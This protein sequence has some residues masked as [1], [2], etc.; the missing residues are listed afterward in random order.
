M[1]AELRTS[2]DIDATPERVWQVLTDLPAYPQ[3]NPFVTA[4]E[5][6]VAEG[7]RLSLT[8]LPVN[9]LIRPTL[10]ATVVEAVPGQRLR[11]QSRMDRLGLPGLLDVEHTISLTPNGGGVRLWQDSHMSGLLLPLT[12]GALNRRRLAAFHAMNA[13]LKDRSEAAPQMT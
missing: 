11:L 2:V 4:A 9:A 1:T 10:R 5:G 8:L 13:A 6:T 12:I 3:W 7:S